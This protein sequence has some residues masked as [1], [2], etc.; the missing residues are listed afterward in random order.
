MI[1]HAKVLMK[2]LA[3]LSCLPQ[4]RTHG[5]F[6]HMRKGERQKWTHLFSSRSETKYFLNILNAI[7]GYFHACVLFHMNLTIHQAL[8]RQ[9]V[10]RDSITSG[11]TMAVQSL[12]QKNMAGIGD[13]RGRVA[14]YAHFPPKHYLEESH[15][16]SKPSPGVQVIWLI[17]FPGW[18]PAY[19]SLPSNEVKSYSLHPVW[20]LFTVSQSAIRRGIA[21]DTLT[22]T[23]RRAHVNY[24]V[25]TGVKFLGLKNTQDAD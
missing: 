2:S 4:Q 21:S 23:H 24:F 19:S 13:L 12:D 17:N 15:N 18:Q 9:I 25:L 7:F 22:D 11:T 8:E 16:Y 20:Q 5:S 3:V 10:Q 14:R 6:T 1:I